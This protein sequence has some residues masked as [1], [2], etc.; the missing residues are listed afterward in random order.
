MVK[1]EVGV[2][3]SESNA[4]LQKEIQTWIDS[5][6]FPPEVISSRFN[7]IVLE[8]GSS[9]KFVSTDPRVEFSALVIIK[10]S[11]VRL[12]SND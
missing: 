7:S 9:G 4:T 6:L 8:P 1:I 2:F 5:F 12:V 3:A 10:S 11:K